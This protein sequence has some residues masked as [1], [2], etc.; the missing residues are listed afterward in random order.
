MFESSSTTLK[1]SIL[2]KNPAYT[3]DNAP[4]HNFKFEAEMSDASVH[5]WFEIFEKVLAYQGFS[6]A[7]I[8]AGCCQLAFN[9]YREPE[10]MRKTAKDYDLKLIE[11][12]ESEEDSTED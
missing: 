10:L 1:I 3:L 6:E 12:S 9:E 8:C 7:N 5:A 4:E 11:Y 2:Y